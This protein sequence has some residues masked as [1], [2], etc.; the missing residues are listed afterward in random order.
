[1][2]N[3]AIH[4]IVDGLLKPVIIPK[5]L[6]SDLAVKLREEGVYPVQFAE[7]TVI[8]EGFVVVAKGTKNGVMIFPNIND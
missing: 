4:L 6:L 2:K 3:V 7:E 5:E 1:M 8:A